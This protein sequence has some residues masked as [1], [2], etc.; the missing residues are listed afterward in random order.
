MTKTRLF[1]TFSAILSFTALAARMSEGGDQ[2]V[3][4]V[5]AVPRAIFDC[6]GADQRFTC[7][8]PADPDKRFVCHGTGSAS[9]PYVKVSTS[10][11]SSH[12]PGRAHGNGT[13]ADQ[14]PGASGHD[15][16]S[17]PGLDC[18][19]NERLCIGVCTGS[20]GGAACDDGDRCTG[21]GSCLGDQC[22]PGPP[23]C[24]AGT[25]VDA[26]NTQ[27]GACD[28]VIGECSTDPAPAGTACGTDQVCNGSGS[29]VLQVVINEI[30]SSGGTPGDWVELFNAGA[31]PA[32]VSGWTFVDNDDA[33]TRYVIPAAT[34]IDAGGYLVL[35]EARFGFGLGS[36]DS[37]RLFDASGAP[38]DSYSWTSHAVTTYGRCANGAGAFGATVTVTKGAANDCLPVRINEIESSGGV[39][40]DWVEL[41]NAGATAVDLSGWVFKDNDDTHSYSVPSGTTMPPGTY[42]LLEEAAFGFGLGSADSARLFD[43]QGDRIDS[44]AWTSHAPITYGRCPNGTGAF[45][46]TASVTKGAANACSAGP[47]PAQAW[48]GTNTV[49]TVDATGVFG[50]NL[51]GLFYEP[52]AGPSSNV[53]WAVRNGPSTLF[54]LV[55]NG[56]VWTPE[57]ANGWDT[58]KTLRYPSGTGSPDSEDVTKAELFSSALYVATERDNDAGG[59]SRLSVL[60]FD[61]DQ[62]GSELTATH[63]WNLNADLPAVGPNLGLEGI[64]W[65]PDSFLVARSFFDETAGHPYVPAQYPN[66]GTGLFFVGVEASGVIYA[67]ALDHVGGGFSRVA[68][69]ASG[70][71]IAK[72]IYF[73]RDVGYLWAQ[74]GAACDNQLGVLA[75]DTTVA[76]PTFGRFKLR[77]QFARPSTMPNIANEGLAIAPESECMSGFKGFFWADDGETGGHAL[78]FD[79]IPC[80][81]FIP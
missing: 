52:A 77:R 18:D 57:A 30:E 47:P 54:R 65:I 16:G 42:F 68:T 53:L 41:F 14:S 26:C 25:P 69:I 59:V 73:D 17:G 28:A 21:D 22:Q 24:T 32:D 11:N 2:A 60:R 35:E 81:S 55:W 61:A 49:V 63:E 10:A 62:H 50:G 40:G 3:C 15:V 67:Y 37:A 8:A 31:G 39:P 1:R 74:C 80:G 64:T 76:S 38:V 70:N 29:C 27:N 46:T 7:A 44:Y 33:H 9:K 48:P 13:R 45:G 51:S 79:A 20:V 12:T 75:I 34:V 5:A 19:C 72:G 36:A 66:H 6:G 78:R 4:S 56:S 58:G 43:A 23:K 71:A